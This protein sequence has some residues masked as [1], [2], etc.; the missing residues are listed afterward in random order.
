MA[1]AAFH[2]PAW[3]RPFQAILQSK[4]GFGHTLYDV[5]PTGELQHRESVLTVKMQRD[6]NIDAF[7]AR[8]K[9]EQL[10]QPG[11]TVEFISNAGKLDVVKITR[12]RN[13]SRS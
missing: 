7:I 8:L 4:T 13:D 6:E 5:S 9:A 1:V 2:R 12:R 3:F 11:D 10:W